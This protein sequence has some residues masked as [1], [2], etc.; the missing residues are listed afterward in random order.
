MKADLA[1]PLEDETNRN[2][3]R[4]SHSTGHSGQ[5]S[6]KELQ[7]VAAL[8]AMEVESALDG[9]LLLQL[10]SGVQVDLLVQLE[11]VRGPHRR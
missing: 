9:T 10:L 2:L 11:E 5:T 4:H 8:V 1:Q 3:S 6:T 7:L